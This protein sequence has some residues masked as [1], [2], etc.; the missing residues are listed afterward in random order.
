MKY[1]KVMIICANCGKK[2]PYRE[3]D[4]YRIAIKQGDKTSVYDNRNRF[5]TV[6][7]AREFL[8]E[9]KI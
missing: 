1:A 6:A 9:V 7:C 8:K 4:L 2:I 3:K 5:C